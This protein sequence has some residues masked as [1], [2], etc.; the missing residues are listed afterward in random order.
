MA[1]GIREQQFAMVWCTETDDL[2]YARVKYGYA[3]CNNCGSTDHSR[4]P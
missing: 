3:F 4:I 1:E 2:A